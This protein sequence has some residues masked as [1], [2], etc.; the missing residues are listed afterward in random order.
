MKIKHRKSNVKL[1]QFNW[2]KIT[3]KNINIFILVSI[4]FIIFGLLSTTSFISGAWLQKTGKL[5]N[6]KS[7]VK[8]FMQDDLPEYPLIPL[9]T[10]AGM[11][12]KVPHLEINIKHKNYESLAKMRKT[13]LENVLNKQFEY[14]P[15]TVVYENKENRCK[16]RLKG[17]RNIHYMDERQWSFRVSMKGDERF[18]GLKKFFLQKPR[19]RNYIYEWLYHKMLKEEGLVALKYDF[20]KVTLNGMDLGLYVIEEY[21][22][23]ELI[24]GSRHREG[25]VIEMDENYRENYTYHDRDEFFSLPIT[26]FEM[27]KW[28]VPENKDLL[29][30]AV[31]KLEGFRRKEFSISETFELKVL[32][33]F[34]AVTDLLNMHHG[35]IW[36]SMR[37][38]CNPVTAKLQP[39]GFDGHYGAYIDWHMFLTAEFAH[40]D[41]GV[42]KATH[43]FSGEW[44]KLLFGKNKGNEQFIEEYVHQLIRLSKPSYLNQFIKRN[45]TEINRILNLIYADSLPLKDYGLNFGPE[46]F[47]FN[48]D[49]LYRAQEYI[50]SRISPPSSVKLVRS[51]VLNDSDNK[52]LLN[53]SNI[54]VLPI[55][56]SGI[57]NTK[58]Q[59][60]FNVNDDKY[61]FPSLKSK[62]K[63]FNEVKFQLQNNANLN[64]YK[65]DELILEFKIIGTDKI[66]KS[67]I[68]PWN[69]KNTSV[70]FSTVSFQDKPLEDLPFV[71]H[72]KSNK[73]IYFKKGS[74]TLNKSISIPE[75]LNV[76]IENGFQLNLSENAFLLSRSPINAM[77][78]SEDPIIIQSF[79]STGGGIFIMKTKGQSL[80]NHVYFQNLSNPQQGGWKLTGAVTFYEADVHMEN[81]IFEK[82]RSEDAL[83]IIR[84]NFNAISCLF[85]ATKSDAFDSDFSSGKLWGVSFIDCGNDGFDASGSN[86]ELRDII[87]YNCGDKGVSGGEESKLSINNLSVK[88]SNIGIASKDGSYILAQNIKIDSCNYGI[89]AFQKKPEYSPSKIDILS[90]ESSNVQD[91]YLLEKK[92]IVHLDGVLLNNNQ[93][94][95]KEILYQEN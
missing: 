40:N 44:Y 15:A 34:F 65:L 31:N 24:E 87:V 75:G 18:Q 35:S 41:T 7:V 51:Y 22:R 29:E 38:Y 67:Q 11:F 5:Q 25:P 61:I 45:Q 85:K 74:W 66:F 30:L 78:T 27:S 89:T 13:A 37:F 47:V 9:R 94:N 16:I 46:L 17:E 3:K 88:N 6:M 33:K 90:I 10:V 93:T 54:H 26:P 20:I 42:A 4:I 81:C 62:H 57:V 77:G 73:T 56:I 82:N 58:G 8:G 43:A 52:L 95:I 36:K 2:S 60:I 28:I 91:L 50:M 53:I 64:E 1:P 21:A 49:L 79:D 92:S 86:I 71:I 19:T 72:D 39:I 59:S 12:E 76:I 63:E 80:L 68:L 23:K 55:E 83:N 14:V 32:A 48:K 69:N 70:N 84:S